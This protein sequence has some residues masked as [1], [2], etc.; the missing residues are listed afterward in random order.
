MA[1]TERLKAEADAAMA[2]YASTCELGCTPEQRSWA[3]AHASAALDVLMAEERVELRRR[4][5]HKTEELE[6]A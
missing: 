2:R 6:A 5:S 3:Y 4:A 1:T